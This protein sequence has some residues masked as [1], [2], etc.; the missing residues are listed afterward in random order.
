MFA[1]KGMRIVQFSGLMLF[2]ACRLKMATG[3]SIKNIHSKIYFI[4]TMSALITT[5][6]I[7]TSVAFLLFWMSTSHYHQGMLHLLVLATICRRV[8]IGLET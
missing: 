6:Y 5:Q 2:N 3:A 1:V 4:V 8:S 7:S